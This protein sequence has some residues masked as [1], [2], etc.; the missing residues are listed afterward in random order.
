MGIAL[1]I[2]LIAGA[3]TLLL[4]DVEPVPTWFYVFVWYPTLVLLD[5]VAHR[6]D[7]RPRLLSGS[8]RLAS[9]FGWSAVIWLLFEA[10]NF[11]LENWYY[12]QLP[13]AAVERWIGIL[14]S[15]ATV[16]PALLLAARLLEALGVGRRWR[17]APVRIRAWELAAAQ[18]VGAAL[19]ALALLWPER[20]FPVI[21]GAVWLLVDPVVYRRRAQWSLLGDLARGDWGRIGRLMLGGAGIGLLWEFY[22]YWARGKW[23]Y[24]VPW[25][26]QLKLF[27]M[28]PMGFLG[29]PLFALEAWALYHLLCI[30]GVA[31]PIADDGAPSDG[32]AQPGAR[33]TAP[34]R[35]WRP[36]RPSARVTATVLATAF[37]ALVLWGMERRTISS[38][39]PRLAD[40][41]GV[42]PA[43][44]AAL[45]A[46]DV[47][48]PFQLA[49]VRPD[50]VPPVDVPAAELARAV[51]AARLSTLR[52]LGTAHAAVLWRIGVRSVCALGLALPERLWH[53]VHEHAPGRHR[54]TRREVRIWVDAAR[55]RCPAERNTAGTPAVCTPRK[56]SDDDAGHVTSDPGNGSLACRPVPTRGSATSAF[57]I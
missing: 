36:A 3:W 6:L 12:V 44:L 21:W 56:V 45:R 29:F 1:P 55:R 4:V 19:G 33:R 15:F 39:V 10:A 43:T 5:R 48:S 46:A 30:A 53:V 17:T 23:I 24:T 35:T 37:A 28:P 16:V 26:E 9:L 8:G 42:Q 32:A 34:H 38:T 27:E 50:T 20:F 18:S 51:E 11:R 7:G 49:R 14:L 57:P 13:R 41:P 54:P 31:L 40:L 47:R 25:L 22:N 52:G 2:L